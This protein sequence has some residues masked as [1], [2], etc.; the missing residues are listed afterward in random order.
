MSRVVELIK[1]LYQNDSVMMTDFIRSCG[2]NLLTR[3]EIMELLIWT[4]DEECIPDVLSEIKP[5]DP[6]KAEH[7]GETTWSE[8]DMKNVLDLADIP[9]TEEN[10]DTLYDA[11]DE[12]DL[13][14]AMV[15]SGWYYLYSIRD[16]LDNQ[17]KFKYEED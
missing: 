12:D 1:R 10:L 5:R 16:E 6:R 7:F 14:Y 4:G 13:I 3:E 2:D 11:I 17:D 9:T 15:E 8:D